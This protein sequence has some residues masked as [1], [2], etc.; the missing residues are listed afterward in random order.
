MQCELC[1]KEVAALTPAIVEGTSMCI[2]S[3]CLPF[4]KI[5]PPPKKS[6]S[7]KS[8]HIERRVIANPGKVIKE[9][10]EKRGLRQVDF[11]KVLQIKDSYLHHIETNSHP[12]DMAL[13]KRIQEALN[14][15]LIKEFSLKSTFESEAEDNSFTLADFMKKK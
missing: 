7:K 1:G 4:G 8:S 13:A 5:I 9:A 15:T 2:C 3:S 6:F 11:A 10:R 14:I 12:L